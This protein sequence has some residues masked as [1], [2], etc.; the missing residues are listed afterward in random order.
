VKRK[1]KGAYIRKEKNINNYYVSHAWINQKNSLADKILDW[2]AAMLVVILIN[3]TS[4]NEQRF[5]TVFYKNQ[6]LWKVISTENIF[7][8][9]VSPIKAKTTRI[10]SVLAMQII[11]Y[12]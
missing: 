3:R 7:A 5:L 4:W 2:N 1:L 8:N 9:P 11:I 10:A 12:V 6:K